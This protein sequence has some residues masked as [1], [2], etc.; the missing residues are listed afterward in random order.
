[1]QCLVYSGLTYEDEAELCY[2]LDKEKKC[3]SLSQSTNA[4]C[5]LGAP[6]RACAAQKVQQRAG[7]EKALISLS[8]IGE[9]T[10]LK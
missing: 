9:A 8:G 3:L 7:W 1:M 6:L 2:K 5:E 4:Y 10:I